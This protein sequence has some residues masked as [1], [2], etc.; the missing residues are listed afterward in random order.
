M[1]QERE[2]RSLLSERGQALLEEI[3]SGQVLGAGNHIR[4]I[5]NVMVEISKMGLNQEEAVRRCFVVGNYFKE[6]RGKSSYAVVN[7][8]NQIVQRITEGKMEIRQA[9]EEYFRAAQADGQK[10]QRYF[11]EMAR[12]QGWKSLIVFDYSSTVE[13][14]IADLEQ[15]MDLYIPESRV[16][17]GGRPFVKPFVQAGHQVHFLADAAMMTV[18]RKMDAAVIGAETFYPDGS[19]FNTAGSDILAELCM[20]FQIPYY[21][22]TPLL[23]VDMRP[24]RGGGKE[25]V[26]ADLSGRLGVGWDREFMEQVDFYSIELVRIWPQRI[27]AFITEEGIIPPGAMFQ[28]VGEYQKKIQGGGKKG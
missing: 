23:K 3:L 12:N 7:A 6:T 27:T 28:I 15:P 5:G 11:K 24:L 22:L 8:I 26:G 13:A 16:I 4:M 2:I 10:I 20:L 19:A 21:V 25:A 14:C 17:D 18:I 1:S 9:V